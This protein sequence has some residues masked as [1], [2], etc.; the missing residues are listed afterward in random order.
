MSPPGLASSNETK[1]LRWQPELKASLNFP[2][3]SGHSVT[4]RQPAVFRATAWVTAVARPVPMQL[5]AQPFRDLNPDSDVWFG[6]PSTRPAPDHPYPR[7]NVTTRRVQFSRNDKLPASL[8]YALENNRRAPNCRAAEWGPVPA[9][10]EPLETPPS[11]SGPA[12]TGSSC[13]LGLGP[14]RISDGRD[15][16]RRF[17]EPL[18]RCSNGFF[19]SITHVQER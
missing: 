6:R 10:C 16:R 3:F 4:T 14:Q 2:L 1:N 17:Q 15:M 18:N 19:V 12:K 8:R 5:V 7:Q 13:F 11:P 9:L